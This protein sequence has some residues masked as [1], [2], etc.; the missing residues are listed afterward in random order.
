MITASPDAATRRI[1]RDQ[2]TARMRLC[3]VQGKI[4]SLGS[5]YFHRSLELH[6][7]TNVTIPPTWDYLRLPADPRARARAP[8]S[9]Y[10]LEAVSSPPC[11]ASGCARAAAAWRQSGAP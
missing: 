8:G 7:F 1:L 11:D 9:I 6:I 3:L 5:S 10:R 2:A 4:A